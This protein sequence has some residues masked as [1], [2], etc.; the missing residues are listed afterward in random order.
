MLQGI[1]TPK[2][3]ATGR[4]NSDND[5]E[6]WDKDGQ[7]AN[8]FYGDDWQV[9]DGYI[10]AELDAPGFKV[11]ASLVRHLVTHDVG[12]ETGRTQHVETFRAIPEDTCK[13]DDGMRKG[14]W[15]VRSLLLDTGQTVVYGYIPA[16]S[17]TWNRVPI[18]IRDMLARHGV[19]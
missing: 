6:A 5:R 3:I 4:N 2:G 7:V 8:M 15:Q 19:S 12:Q 18:M 10:S 17:D 9:T 1:G 11:P 16:G 13:D 14:I